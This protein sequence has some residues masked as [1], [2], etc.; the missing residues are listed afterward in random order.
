MILL[1]LFGMSLKLVVLRGFVW[2]VGVFGK[3]FCQVDIT[4]I[5]RRGECVEVDGRGM[6]EAELIMG[7]LFM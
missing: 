2:L 4:Q 6:G 3:A 5:F 1:I 7:G